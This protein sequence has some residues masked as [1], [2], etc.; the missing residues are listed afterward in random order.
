MIYTVTLNPSL[1]YIVKV[2]DFKVGELNRTEDDYINVGGKGIMVSK[3]LTNLQTP[4]IALGFLG[5]FT[6]KYI[7]DWFERNG[8]NHDFTEVKGNTRINVK[9]KSDTES[10]INAQGPCISKEEQHIFLDKVKQLSKGDTLIISGSNISGADSDIIL[11][12][13]EICRKKGADFV[14]DTTGK[15]LMETL[16]YQ[17]LLIK[18]NLVELGEL[19]GKEIRSEEEAIIYGKKC[20]EAGAKYVIISM[21]DRGALFLD[22]VQSYYAKAIP[23]KLVN[24]VGAGDSMIAGFIAAFQRD[25]CPL[26][27]FRYAVAAGTATAFCKDIGSQKEIEHYFSKV[28]IQ[29]PFFKF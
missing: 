10:E 5:G 19:F 8:L 2:R 14:I 11:Q 4:N 29:S 15:S 9:L 24:S 16:T 7:L 23:G 21:G 20:L 17:P 1:D 18:P 3:L 27:S 12:M 26:D 6:G 22:G 25:H 13:I 28:E